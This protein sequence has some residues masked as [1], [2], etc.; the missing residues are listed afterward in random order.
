MTELE[1]YKLRLKNELDTTS[2]NLDENL[3]YTHQYEEAINNTTAIIKTDRNNI[4][5]YVNEKFCT[6]SGYSKEEVIGMDCA[7]YETRKR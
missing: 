4:I 7:Q 1:E 6:L 2:Y 3:N 5:T